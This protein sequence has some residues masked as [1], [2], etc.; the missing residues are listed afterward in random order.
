L[1]E[2]IS[3]IRVDVRTVE[4]CKEIYKGV[5]VMLANRNFWVLDL[6]FCVFYSLAT[7]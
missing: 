7:I 1:L 5:Y 2:D 4:L 3:N 6:N